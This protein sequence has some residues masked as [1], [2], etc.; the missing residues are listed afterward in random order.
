[1]RQILE[2]MDLYRVEDDQGDGDLVFHREV[3]RGRRR[4][5]YHD[6]GFLGIQGVREVED[7]LRELQRRTRDA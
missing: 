6:V 4:D 3:R 5:T 2:L 7:L 1:M